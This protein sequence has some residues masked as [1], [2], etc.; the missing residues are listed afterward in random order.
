MQQSSIRKPFLGSLNS[1]HGIND[2]QPQP[3]SLAENQCEPPVTEQ[4]RIIQKDRCINQ[5]ID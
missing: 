3:V 1:Q 2:D 5:Q 4:C